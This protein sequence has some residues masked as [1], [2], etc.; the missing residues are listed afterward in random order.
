LKPLEEASSKHFGG[1]GFNQ[2]NEFLANW[3]LANIRD[4]LGLYRYKTNI[5]LGVGQF[6]S[7]Q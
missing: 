3:L 4:G 5:F 6:N 1:I 2:S 7:R